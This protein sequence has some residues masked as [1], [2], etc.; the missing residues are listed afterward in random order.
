MLTCLIS[1]TTLADSPG[2]AILVTCDYIESPTGGPITATN[3]DAYEMRKTFEYLNYVVH[4]LQNEEATLARILTL[5]KHVS[6][7]LH[8]YS[9]PVDDDKVII[10]AFS[11]IGKSDGS[12]K[13]ITVDGQQLDF[14]D[15]IVTPLMPEAVNHIPKLFFVDACRGSQQLLL[16]HYSIPSG[17]MRICGIN[18]RMEYATMAGHAASAKQDLWMSKLA[19][20][21]REQKDSF[22]NIADCIKREV[23]I[24]TMGEQQCESVN[25]LNTGPLRLTK[26]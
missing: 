3:I 23:Y 15:D 1:G 7:D 8:K 24:E 13:I 19:R 6:H 5:L 25:R 9:G 18:C 4:Q 20:A 16:P 22:Q 2:L 14:I 11:G 21:L 26:L 10:F 17:S 12:D